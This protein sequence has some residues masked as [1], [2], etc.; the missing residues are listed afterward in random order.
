M[1]LCL[2]GKN[3]GRPIEQV[4]EETGLTTAQVEGERASRQGLLDH[5]L[6]GRG[7][8]PGRRPQAGR[9]RASGGERV[10]AG[11]QTRRS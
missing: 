11:G 5:P 2:H 7:G 10:A 8:C 6:T 9:G 3:T 4:A 1:D